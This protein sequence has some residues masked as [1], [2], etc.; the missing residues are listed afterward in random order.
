MYSFNE[1][2]GAVESK[3][4]PPE[5]YDKYYM[6]GKNIQAHTI[7]ADQI[8]AN[9]LTASEITTD[10]LRGINGWINLHSGTFTF[11]GKSEKVIIDDINKDKKLLDNYISSWESPRGTGGDD[12]RYKESMSFSPIGLNQEKL[13]SKIEELKP[14][15]TDSSEVLTVLQK[16]TL[17]RFLGELDNYIIWLN[18]NDKIYKENKSASILNQMTRT[19]LEKEFGINT[20]SDAERTTKYNLIKNY[21]GIKEASE[22]DNSAGLYGMERT[23]SHCSW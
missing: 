1:S 18:V 21:V 22:E 2:L 6:G 14:Y 10:D 11:Y 23:N 16:S 17:T 8:L 5:D 13:K 15:T 7:T 3:N 19:D 12:L 9:S 20:L 4:I